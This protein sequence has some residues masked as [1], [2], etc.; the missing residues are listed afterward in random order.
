[1]TRAG[2]VGAASI[3]RARTALRGG[4][5]V[6]PRVVVQYGLL[7][8]LLFLSAVP[9]VMMLSMSVRNSTLIYTDF[10]GLPWPPYFNNFTSALVHLFPPLAR[11]LLVFVTSI[12]FM[13][14]FAATSAYAFARLRFPGRAKLFYLFI[15]VMMVPGTILLTPHFILANQLGLRDS[16]LGLSVFYIAGGQPFAVFLLSAF[17]QSQP[18]EMFESARVDGASELRALWSIAVP[19]SWPII[20]TLAILNFTAIY[21]DLI[22]PMLM[23]TTPAKQTLVVALQRYNPGGGADVISALPDLGGQAAGYAFASIPQLV[24]FVLGMRYFIQGLTSGAVK[25]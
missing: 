16:L 12:V 4:R 22:W 18:A 19:L 1:M 14:A 9:I 2:S 5:R 13:L 25:G 8:A 20:I 11:T 24:V 10:W 6:Q 23:L 15:F 21:N 7:A 17:F 3:A